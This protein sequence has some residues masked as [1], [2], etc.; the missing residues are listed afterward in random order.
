MKNSTLVLA[1]ILV[2]SYIKLIVAKYDYSELVDMK[3]YD[4]P[5]RILDCWECF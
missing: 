5:F 4:K 1:L 3:D 2:V